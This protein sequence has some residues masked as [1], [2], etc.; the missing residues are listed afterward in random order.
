MKVNGIEGMSGFQLQSEV[1]RGGKFV[2]YKYCIS[3]LVITFRRTSDVYFI[4]PDESGFKYAVQYTLLSLLLGW[5]GFPWG[6]IY[7]FDAL[8]TNL[9]GGKDVT[10]DMVRMLGQYTP[11]Y[12]SIST[13][14]DYFGNQ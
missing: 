4:R 2:M 13:Q 10:A 6:I 9:G 5:W 3:A 7:T 1:N 11:R 12:D 14:Q 8:F